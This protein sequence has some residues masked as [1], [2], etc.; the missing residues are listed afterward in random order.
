MLKKNFNIL[1]ALI[2]LLFPVIS[3]AED[4]IIPIVENKILQSDL[5]I[6]DE[7]V[8]IDQLVDGNVYIMGNNVTIDTEIG[9]NVFVMANTVN[10]TENAYVYSTVIDS[11][12]IAQN[13][14]IEDERIYL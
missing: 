7:N 3:Y 1:T 5:Y 6:F 11:Y 9:G 10:L 2:L 4:D 13:T 8:V 12:I 14:S